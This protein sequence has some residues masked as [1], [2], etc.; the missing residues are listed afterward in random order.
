[1][2]A[3]ARRQD[4]LVVSQLIIHLAVLDLRHLMSLNKINRK[5]I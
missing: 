1:M 4:L 5:N 2:Y 3:P